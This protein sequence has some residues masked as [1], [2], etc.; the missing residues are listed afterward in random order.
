MGTGTIKIH[1]LTIIG[2]NKNTEDC[3]EEEL[4]RI[5]EMMTRI[6]KERCSYEEEEE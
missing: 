2:G 1:D 5:Y 3:T 6:I 4:E